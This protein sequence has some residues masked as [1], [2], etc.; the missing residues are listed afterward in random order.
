MFLLVDI[1]A[2]VLAGDY[3]S[4][5]ENHWA[6][7]VLIQERVLWRVDYATARKVTN[8]DARRVNVLVSLQLGLY[9]L[10]VLLFGV[11]F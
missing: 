9:Y 3:K 11:H 1:V 8:G 6:M 4:P 2:E 7:T 10:C 5:Y